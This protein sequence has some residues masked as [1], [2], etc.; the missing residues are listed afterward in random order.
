MF[1]GEVLGA[2]AEEVGDSRPSSLPGHGVGAEEVV[3]SRRGL[4]RDT[5]KNDGR[6]VQPVGPRR[7]D[8]QAVHAT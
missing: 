6:Q 3:H 7:P 8:I 4:L 1:S 5:I 2:G